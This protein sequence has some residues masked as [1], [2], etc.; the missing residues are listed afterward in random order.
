MSFEEREFYLQLV[1]EV[2]SEVF[3]IMVKHIKINKIMQK[4]NIT[5]S[6]YNMDQLKRT[7]TNLLQKYMHELR[8]LHQSEIILTETI[9]EKEKCLYKLLKKPFKVE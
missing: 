3:E 2:Y 4:V 6:S 5:F 8:I 9:E 7:F 1:S